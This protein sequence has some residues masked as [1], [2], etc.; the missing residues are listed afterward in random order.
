MIRVR[1][2]K[3][4]H[5]GE[6]VTDIQDMETRCKRDHSYYTDHKKNVI[7]RSTHESDKPIPNR[8]D[9]AIAASEVYQTQNQVKPSLYE[10]LD[11]PDCG[12]VGTSDKQ[13]HREA[14]L[15]PRANQQFLGAGSVWNIFSIL[16][17]CYRRSS[18]KS[19]S[20]SE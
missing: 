19:I 12:A 11:R 2:T 3:R 8:I 13:D 10:S 15:K 1:T 18:R 4:P 14:S 7:K 5:C 17:C 6:I 20:S 16:T 9:V